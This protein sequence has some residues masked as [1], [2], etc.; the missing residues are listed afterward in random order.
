MNLNA[1]VGR[2]QEDGVW[3][4]STGESG[5]LSGV[6][7]IEHLNGRLEFSYSDGS[8]QVSGLVRNSG[9]VELTGT[10]G[11]G[12]LFLGDTSL[13]LEY[14]ADVD[15]RVEYNTDTWV[16]CEC[17]FRRAGVIRQAEKHIWFEAKMVK[18]D[19]GA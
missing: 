10:L 3:R 15:G 18:D 5:L 8:R 13:T 4:A 6:V 9:P 19:G 12:K 7:S 2:Y 16:K 14:E 1:I 17:C 11:D